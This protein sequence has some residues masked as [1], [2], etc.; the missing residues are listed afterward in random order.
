MNTPQFTRLERTA[1]TR[2]DEAKVQTKKQQNIPAYSNYEAEK[3]PIDTEIATLQT[4]EAKKYA[5]EAKHS[6]EEAKVILLKNQKKDCEEAIAKLKLEAEKAKAI[7]KK[8]KEATKK[9]N[10]K[11]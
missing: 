5:E 1:E 6:A 10:R 9:V 4:E 7:L 8:H 3:A 2:A 11:K